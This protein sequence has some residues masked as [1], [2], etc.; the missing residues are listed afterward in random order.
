[1]PTAQLIKLR[2][3]TNHNLAHLTARFNAAISKSVAG[4][5]EAGNVLLEGKAELNHGQF[6]AWV[7]QELHWDIRKAEMLMMLARHPILSKSCNYTTL[8]PSYRS[9][10][11]LSQM[12]KQKLT[13]LLESGKIN[14]SMTID[15]VVALRVRNTIKGPQVPSRT[16][17]L[18]KELRSLIDAAIVLGGGDVVLAYIRDI[19]D[20]RELK[21]TTNEI[22]SSAHWVKQRLRRKPF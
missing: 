20:I 19:P 1:M 21:P 9:L 8:P 17:K 11:N 6:M 22:D 4:L 5:I 7:V 2:T 12:P 18:R 16:P 3:T 10:W 15:E 13:E 14:S